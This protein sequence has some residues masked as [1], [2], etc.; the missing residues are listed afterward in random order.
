MRAQAAVAGLLGGL[1]WLVKLVLDV[2]DVGGGLVGALTW[3]GS[4]LLVVAT[5]AA[6]AGMVNRSTSWLRVVVAV[7]F[8]AL[9]TSVLQVLRDAGDPMAVDA[10][11][12]LVA[13]VASVLV[14]SRS[15]SRRPDPAPAGRRIRGS[16]AR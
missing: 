16:H 10:A 1:F 4:A 12:G 2:V 11:V 13:V 9:A 6:G 7:G 14:L 8:V 5:L 15:R 3:A